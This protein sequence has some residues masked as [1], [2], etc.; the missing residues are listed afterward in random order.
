VVNIVTGVQVGDVLAGKYRVEK[1][2]GSGS[3][4]IV[5][6]AHDL[7]LD[8]RVAKPPH[9]STLSATSIYDDRL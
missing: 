1:I 3:M 6:A 2:V 8:E 9:P 5:A 7:Q 4:G